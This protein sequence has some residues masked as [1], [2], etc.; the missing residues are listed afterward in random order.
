M[1][2]NLCGI[3]I[4]CRSPAGIVPMGKKVLRHLGCSNVR[5]TAEGGEALS[6]MIREIKPRLIFMEAGFYDTAT[7]YMAGQLLS[8]KPYLR[9]AVFSLA[10]YSEELEQA[11]VLHGVAGYINLQDGMAE[12]YKGLKRILR[13][14]TYISRRV[15]RRIDELK[16]LPP[17]RLNDSEREDEVMRLLAE[18]HTAGEIAGILH[19]ASRTVDRHKNNLFKRYHVRNTAGLIKT[20]FLLGKI[21]F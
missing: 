18:G 13:G 12:C 11:F 17:L 6:R 2:K 15:R 5:G 3:L 10:E 14:E 7:P 4:V 16:E 19:I 20:G 8:K 21:K 9:I 1:I